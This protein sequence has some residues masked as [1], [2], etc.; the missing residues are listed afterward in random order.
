MRDGFAARARARS[1][2]RSRPVEVV[3]DLV[4][5]ALRVALARRRRG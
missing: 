1:M 2:R 4:D 5:P 3:V